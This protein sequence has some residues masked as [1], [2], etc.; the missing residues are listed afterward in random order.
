MEVLVLLVL[1]AGRYLSPGRREVGTMYVLRQLTI[2]FI[3]FVTAANVISLALLVRELLRGLQTDGRTLV[4]SAL[5]IWFTNV[6]AFALWYWE[7]DG[8]GPIPRRID[9]SGRRDFLFPQMQL[10]QDEEEQALRDDRD[11][12]DGKHPKRARPKYLGWLPGFT[13]YLYVSFTNSTAFS[14]TDTMPLTTLAKML[15]MVQSA[16]ALLTVALLAARAVNI[17]S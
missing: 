9:P 13:D 3:A 4:L 7:F 17:L 6:I 12:L 10:Q 1:V 8:G 5:T 14:P 2:V 11:A 15:M 16:A